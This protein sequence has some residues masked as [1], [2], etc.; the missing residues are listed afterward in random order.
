MKL[1]KDINNSQLMAWFNSCT[2]GLSA[3]TT[4]FCAIKNIL[5]SYSHLLILRRELHSISPVSWSSQKCF[6]M[7]TIKYF[8]PS[9][10]QP[11]ALEI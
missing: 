2:N 3:G 10:A 5:M 7:P 4:T 8:T 1:K 11:S 6:P 9:A